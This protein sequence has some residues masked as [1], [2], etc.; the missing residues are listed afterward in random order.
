MP[1]GL[2]SAALEATFA[3]LQRM[4]ANALGGDRDLDARAARTS[5]IRA[6]VDTH[7]YADHPPAPSGWTEMMMG[8]PVPGTVDRGTDVLAEH[9][10][11]G[12][13]AHAEVATRGLVPPPWRSSRRRRAGVADYAVMFG[14]L[15]TAPTAPTPAVARPAQR[16][17]MPWVYATEAEAL[18][19]VHVSGCAGVPTHTST[20]RHRHC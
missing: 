11:L 5:R 19:H 14:D 12:R 6:L 3:N 15:I 18:R 1:S 7:A 16:E 2:P 10:R 17:P 13:M 8:L 4:L 9:L 20:S